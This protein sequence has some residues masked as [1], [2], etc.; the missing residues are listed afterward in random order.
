MS[1]RL[2]WGLG[3]LAV[4]FVAYHSNQKAIRTLLHLVEQHT[5]LQTRL[6]QI[7]ELLEP[8]ARKQ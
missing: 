8:P 6:L 5:P 2:R 7:N 3:L 1:R 4:V